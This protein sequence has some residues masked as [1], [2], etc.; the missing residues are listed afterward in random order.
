MKISVIIPVYN[1]EK[2]ITKCLDSIYKT[3]YRDF[4]VI[5]VDDGSTDK[6]ALLIKKYPCRIKILRQNSGVSVARN[7]GAKLARGELLYFVDADVVQKT[8]NLSEI[9]KRL[10]ENPNISV[11]NLVHHW[12]SMNEGF[13][14]EFIGLK[15]YYDYDVLLRKGI[16]KVESSFFQA[17]GGFIP[18]KLFWKIGGFNEKI[19][20]PG[21]E[22][23]EFGHKLRSNGYI[24]SVLL[25]MEVYH[26]WWNLIERMKLNYKRS[27]MWLPLLLKRKSFETKGGVATAKN[28][29][30]SIILTLVLVLS[31]LSIFINII[32]IPILLLIFYFVYNIDFY[33]YIY[34]KKKN[35]GFTILSI[36]AD[37]A[38][39]ISAS[40][41]IITGFIKYLFNFRHI[42]K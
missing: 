33:R 31:L 25:D 24:I 9:S 40:L 11:V 15:Y 41:G 36:F 20:V 5:V 30:N 21:G 2:T 29:I 12:R 34:R 3:K 6:T 14:P 22:E 17:L 7:I 1:G 13:G 27:Q 26:Y 42:I 38:L 10:K 4:E 28:A 19:H 23:F 18:K 39:Y 35:A 32:Y 8:D 37:M 16:M